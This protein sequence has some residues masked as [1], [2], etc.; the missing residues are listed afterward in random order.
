MISF[1]PLSSPAKKKEIDF[2]YKLLLSRKPNISHRKCPSIEEH[3]A[4][5]LNHPYRNWSLVKCDN[6]SIGSI[7]TGFDN[8]VGIT[9]FS[10][11]LSYRKSVIIKFLE[12]FIPL[13]GK[14]SIVRDEFI[15]NVAVKDLEY[16]EDLRKCGAIQIQHTYSIK[17]S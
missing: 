7:Y 3:R 2:L 8:S 6:T 16:Q 1:V 13:P 5:V 12:D 17:K 9:L 15:F 11:F 14:S 4:F 10:E